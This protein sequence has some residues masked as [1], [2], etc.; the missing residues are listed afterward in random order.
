MSKQEI[1]TQRPAANASPTQEMFHNA[2]RAMA[3][4]K[5]FWIDTATAMLLERLT[6]KN[7]DNLSKD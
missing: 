7:K 1:E 4:D 5:A 6:D 2:R 3:R